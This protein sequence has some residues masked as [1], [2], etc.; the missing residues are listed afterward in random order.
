[1]NIEK[2]PVL[3][4]DGNLTP[5]KIKKGGAAV[6]TWLPAGEVYV[7]PVAESAVGKVVIDT[8]FYEGKEVTGL[9]MTFKAGKVTDLKV[10][11]GGER[12]LELYKAAGPGKEKFGAI[13]IGINPNVRLPKDSKLLVFM[14]SGMVS[15]FTGNDTWAGG[16][17][18]GSFG[19]G[20]FLQ[21]TT[22][23]V[24]GRVIVDKGACEL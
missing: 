15:V 3:V 10:K 14:A 2:R 13:D 4:S 16:G 21:G 24:D 8:S 20:G 11:A 19:V 7:T 1:M 9:T 17:N 22:L 18:N 6:Q 23:K 12:L 5:E